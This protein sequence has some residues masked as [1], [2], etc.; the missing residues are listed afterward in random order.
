MTKP[1][2]LPDQTHGKWNR[3]NIFY[4]EKHEE[5]QEDL[6]IVLTFTSNRNKNGE[7]SPYDRACCH[8]LWSSP[9]GEKRQDF[10][11]IMV[12]FTISF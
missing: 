5:I 9:R 8:Y 11:R 7:I 10:L 3:H 4:K 1:I 6:K 2:R 12:D